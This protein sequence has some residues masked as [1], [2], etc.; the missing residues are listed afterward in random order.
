MRAYAAF[1]RPARRSRWRRRDCRR[2]YPTEVKFQQMYEKRHRIL[3]GGANE[4]LDL[5]AFAG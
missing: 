1:L 3:R 2:L 4:R 5:F